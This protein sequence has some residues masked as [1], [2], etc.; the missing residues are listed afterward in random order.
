MIGNEIFAGLKK[1]SPDHFRFD[2]WESN[3]WTLLDLDYGATIGDRDI[4]NKKIKE[5]AIGYCKSMD[6]RIRQKA[7]GYAVM[8]EKDGEEFWFHVPEWQFEGSVEYGEM[9]ELARG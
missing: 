4:L 3:W 7:A 9:S 2:N 1:L 8:F 6:V 5:H